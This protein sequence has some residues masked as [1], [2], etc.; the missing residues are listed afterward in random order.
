LRAERA[1]GQSPGLAAKALSDAYQPTALQL[2]TLLVDVLGITDPAGV[3]EAL[4][5]AGVSQADA[6][7]VLADLFSWLT[8]PER[9][10]Y[11]AGG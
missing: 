5:A 10:A 6:S 3:G 4:R 7:S 9:D 1:A 8:A 11:C 2:G